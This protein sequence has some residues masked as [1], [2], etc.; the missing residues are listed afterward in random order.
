MVAWTKVPA[1]IAALV[2]LFRTVT[3]EVAAT[4]PSTADGQPAEV[5]VF[6]GP[7]DARGRVPDNYVC[8]GYTPMSLPGSYS[9]TA[10]LSVEG[11]VDISEVGNRQL[12]ETFTVEC[13]CS[14]FSGDSDDGA[15]GRQ[16]QRTGALYGALVQALQ[17]DPTVGGVVG[18]FGRQEYACVGGYR[19]LIDPN[20]DGAAVSV[21]FG[22]RVVGELWLPS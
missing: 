12:F 5:V 10:G 18:G 1:F 21:Q 13:E 15:V 2:A 8:V 22:V 11:I 7:P 20:K 4:L 9:P 17:A 19:W 3:V 16:Q 6:N 14:T